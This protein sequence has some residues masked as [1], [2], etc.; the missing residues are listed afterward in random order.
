MMEVFILL[1]RLICYNLFHSVPVKTQEWGKFLHSKKIY[2]DFDEIRQEIELETEK[3]T[4]SN[5]VCKTYSHHD[6]SV[7]L[8]VHLIGSCQ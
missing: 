8:F 4:G 6:I 2:L 5:K 3:L 7:R 1:S